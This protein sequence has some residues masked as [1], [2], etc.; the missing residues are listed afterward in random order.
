MFSQQVFE[1]GSHLGCNSF[2]LSWVSALKN[3]SQRRF[4][5]KAEFY[6]SH[7]FDF[8]ENTVELSIIEKSMMIR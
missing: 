5:S 6:E 7:G 3:P 1:A 8:V 4:K 2:E